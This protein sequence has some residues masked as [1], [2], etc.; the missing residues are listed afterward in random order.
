MKTIKILSVLFSLAF[1]VFMGGF[2]TQLTGIELNFQ[3]LNI[4]SYAISALL[5]AGSLLPLTPVGSLGVYV[6]VS[7][8]KPGTNMGVGGGMYDQIV[9]FDMDTVNK[10]NYPHRD[11]S[12]IKMEAG[13]I[14]FLEGATMIEIYSTP[15]SIENTSKSQGD[16]DAKGFI[17]S[18][19]F[20]H[21]GNEQAIREFRANWLNK[22]VGIIHRKCT[23]TVMDIYGTPCVPLQM[24]ATWTQNKDKNFT[25]FMFESLGVGF[26]VGIYEG[27]LTLPEDSGS[28]A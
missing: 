8:V 26:D 9:F 19:K 1:A 24:Q 15:G 11:D 3:N 4:A 10:D 20:L 22:N 6:A 23:G 25:E 14:A 7:V 21:P 18:C 2:L 27:T 5:F 28:G 17:Q 12:L 13:N 16:P